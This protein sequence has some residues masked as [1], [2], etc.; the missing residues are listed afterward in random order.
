MQT[1]RI[2]RPRREAGYFRLSAEEMGRSVERV[3]L[4]EESEETARDVM[5]GEVYSV[6]PDAGLRENRPDDVAPGHPPGVRQR[7]R[8]PCG[9]ISTTEILGALSA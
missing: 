1:T 2:A 7:G 5:N 9:L 8:P 6:G 4:P 3:G